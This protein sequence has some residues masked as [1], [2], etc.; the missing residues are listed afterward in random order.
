[1]PNDYQDDAPF[2]ASSAHVGLTW[3]RPL[4]GGML[5]VDAEAEGARPGV[6]VTGQRAN[7]CMAAAGR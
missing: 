2:S 4:L 3:T 7:W 6:L 1:M 5:E